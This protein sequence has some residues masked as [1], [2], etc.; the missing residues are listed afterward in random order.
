MTSHDDKIHFSKF[1]SCVLHCAT[2]STR[3]IGFILKYTEISPSTTY[4]KL[5]VPQKSK[6]ARIF[7]VCRC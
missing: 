4:A 1:I 5:G 6:P 2:L 7:T 3:G